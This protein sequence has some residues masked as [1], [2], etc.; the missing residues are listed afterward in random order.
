MALHSEEFGKGVASQGGTTEI[1]KDGHYQN[2]MPRT[3]RRL[4]KVNRVL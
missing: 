4:N 2:D 1:P 3:T